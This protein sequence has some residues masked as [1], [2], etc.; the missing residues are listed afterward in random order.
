MH[1]VALAE[2]LDGDAER[3][4]WHGVAEVLYR[5]R[6]S[7]K[8]EGATDFLMI[9]DLHEPYVAAARTLEDLSYRFVETEPDMVLGL[10]P[11]WRSYDDY[12]SS[13]ASKYRNNVRN[14]ILKPI[15]AAGCRVAPI[16]DV[17]TV[18]TD[19]HRLYL[20]VHQNA[21][22]R[23]FT[24]EPAYFA[25]LQAV[26]GARFRCSAIYREEKILGFLIT[27]AD[28]DL[29]IAYHVGFDREAASELPVYLRLL[30]AA[31]A[32]AIDLG[33]RQLSYGRTALEPK[34][35]LGARPRPFGV[36][37]RHRQPVLNKLIKGLL[38]GIE[39]VEPPE[40]NPFKKKS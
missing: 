6:Q 15:E 4:A 12:L 28:R 9:K 5:V 13:L 23:P 25:A 29:G 32:D 14:G 10:D 20:A 33:C 1:G 31:I 36:L 38:T 16:Q 40:R 2:G 35:A 17:G 19:L 37:L 18:Q 39:H 26:A 30:H 27:L 21:A 8:L 3:R 11:A 22:F 24:L 34:A 7:E